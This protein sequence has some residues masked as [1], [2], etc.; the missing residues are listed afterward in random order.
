MSPSDPDLSIVIV[1]YNV[2]EYIASLILSIRQAAY[3]GR[4]DII[5][6]D[7]ASSDGSQEFLTSRFPDIT[8]VANRDNVG[9]AKANNQ[10]IRQ[11]RTPYTLILN[12][13]TLVSSDTLRVMAAHMAANPDVGA[14]G[15][16]ILN[17]DG[18]FAPESK[19]AVPTPKTALYKI[20]GLSRLFPS[21][22]RFAD[23]HLGW[24]HPDEPADVPVLSGS[25]MFCRTDVLQS[26][27]GFDE[28]FFMYGEDIDLCHRIARAGYRITY[29]PQT[30]I[31]HYKGESTKKDRLDYAILFN[32]AMFQF[33]D[34]HYS[35]GYAMWYKAL[36]KA[37]ILI[38]GTVSYIAARLASAAPA[39][40]DL[41]LINALLFALLLW[42]YGIPIRTVFESYVP[43]FLILHAL[44][45]LLFILYSQYNSLY[46][47]NRY[48]TGA[49]LN[50][51]FLTFAS[52]AFVTFFLRDYA[53]SRW[54]V[55]LGWL[56]GSIL[57]WAV[58]YVPNRWRDGRTTTGSR[59]MI[60]GAGADS[61]DWMTRLAARMSGRNEIVG[62]VLPADRPYLDRIAGLPVL[63]RID[64]VTDLRR[65]HRVDQI[66]FD[67]SAVST[68]DILAVMSQVREPG[69]AFKLVPESMDFMIGKSD[70]V[71]IDRIPLV[72]VDVPYN[73]AW[74][75]FMKRNLDMAI[76]LPLTVV[77]A[78]PALVQ[79]VRVWRAGQRPTEV[80][81]PL[82]QHRSL[83][84]R[85][86]L[87]D[88]SAV[89]VNRLI[90]THA[91]LRGRLSFVG[92]P[93]MPGRSHPPVYCQPGWTGLRQQHEVSGLPT[94]DLERL[95]R[96]YLQTHSL[97]LDILLIW[98][99]VSQPGRRHRYL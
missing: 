45:T 29:V 95:E 2:K 7:N 79:W 77:L 88:A 53:F 31:I 14:A 69:V 70:V 19:R 97:W 59:W 13:D 42:R 98:N 4:V 17:P 35:T 46:G 32:K 48:R 16:K 25:F 38:R 23:Y 9:F 50:T 26:L 60:V 8:F 54:I 43:G 52:L 5:V 65:H 40:A 21:S 34:K 62:V 10:A 75:R 28:R 27:D 68:S 51:M 44:A 11:V 81:F 93:L 82:E 18:T 86:F 3:N 36:V 80:R 89:W 61:Q 64:H 6:I 39:I 15:C 74:N 91:V 49:L 57:L 63:G 84:M 56:F 83:R 33:F 67:G 90:L 47:A 37:G 99:A 22:R 12:P 66:L 1:N 24:I 72:D 55:L 73:R 87:P 94:E 20:L 78:L 30:S 76:A 71:Y 85:L 96:Q 58:R 41:L 92:A